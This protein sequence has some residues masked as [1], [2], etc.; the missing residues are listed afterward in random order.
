MNKV[1]L[2]F[3]LFL[4]LMFLIYINDIVKKIDLFNLLIQKDKTQVIL[5]TLIK[6]NFTNSNKIK[7][8][9]S[10]QTKQKEPIIYIY[11]THQTEEYK[12]SAYNITPTVMTASQILKEELLEYELYSIV[13]EKSIKKGLEENKYDYSYSYRISFD[14]LKKQKEKYPSIKYYFD[15]HRDSVKGDL[16]KTKIKEKNYA[17]LMFLIGENHEK[18]KENVK[19]IKKIENYIEKY[20]PNVLR[21]TYYQPLYSYNQEYDSNMFLIELGGPDNTLEEIYNTSVVLAE[22]INYYIKGETNEK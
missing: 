4:F 22:A 13:E 14:Y 19:N 7:I 15:I 12:S 17:K 8:K 6:S 21:K 1:K 18:Y 11:N 16:S 9:N 5:N 20:Y 2:I 3:C 10:K